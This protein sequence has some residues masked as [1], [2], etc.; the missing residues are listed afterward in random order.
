MRVAAIGYLNA[1]PL[2]EGL[3]WPLARATPA[4]LQRRLA[5]HAYDLALCSVTT[6]LCGNGLFILP[7]VAIGCR[8][9]VRSVRLRLRPGVRDV[10]A[11]RRIALDPESNTANLLLKVLLAYHYDCPLD[12]V[13][14]VPMDAEPHAWLTIGDRALLTPM[15]ETDIDLGAV[16][17]AWTDLPFVFAAWLTPHAAIARDVIA[18]LRATRDRNLAHL[19]ALPPDRTS[20]DLDYFL[21]HILYEF[22]GA[23]RR[24]LAR[25]HEYLRLLGLTRKT[26]LPLAHII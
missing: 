25:F 16:W 13:A 7:G 10:R 5:E 18:T 15:A 17:T 22:D 20:H 4:E 12:T 2:C 26:R 6:A 9:A 3:P 24:G 23:A 19:R 8:G 14:F 21:Q 1:F 11:C